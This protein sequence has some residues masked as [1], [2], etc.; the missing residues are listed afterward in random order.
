MLSAPFAAASQASPGPKDRWEG[1]GR[2]VAIGDIHGDCDALQKTLEVAGA[3]DAN[4]E[5]SGGR[6]H[7]V[8]IGDIPARWPQTR[9]AMDLLMKL[10]GQAEAAGGRLHVLIGNHD[11]M[12]MCRDMRSIVAGEYAEFA[13]AE[14][15]TLVKELLEKELAER[16]AAGQGPKTPREEEG[17][18]EL[19][20]AAHPPGFVE[21]VRAYSPDGKYGSWIRMRNAVLRI[22][23]TVFV[24]G[25]LSPAML[26]HTT[27]H[28][29][30]T[31]RRELSDPANLTPGM[32]T[33]LEGPLWY[34]GLAEGQGAVLANHVAAVM[35]TL[36]V[37]R[38]VIG[39]TVTKAAIEPRFGSRVMNIDLG[40]SRFFGRPPACLVL[41]AAGNHV[42]HA[43]KKIPVPANTPADRSKYFAAVAA[44]DPEPAL[45]KQWVTN[46]ARPRLTN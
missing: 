15:A 34:R 20:L 25:G 1:I 32:T 36:S 13:T 40:L 7:V 37:D 11:A 3:V 31:I 33:S 9:K 27:I 17:F 2:V 19:W 14:S 10:E 41:E 45:I 6:T 18:K 35:T 23:R 12:P 26:K 21:L 5:W 38:I 30:Q 44:A 42:I 46:L 39:H 16:N 24:H 43:G 28:I 8:Q 29:N 22:N 4:G